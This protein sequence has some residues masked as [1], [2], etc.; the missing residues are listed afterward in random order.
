MKILVVRFKQI[1]DSILTGPLCYSLKKSFPDAQ[2]DY[3]VYDHIAPLFEK[4]KY[5]D[6]VISITKEERKQLCSLIK[7]LPLTI[8]GDH[9]FGEAVITRGGVDV[10]EINPSTMESKILKGLY[11]AG[12]IVDVDG[13]C[14]GYNLQWAWSSGYV[15]GRSCAA[16]HC[17]TEK[18]KGNR[19]ETDNQ[20]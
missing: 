6:N 19:K 18:Q 1:G 20:I 15:A 3:V 14:G 11:F 4:N 5:I 9:G 13:I 7:S 2:V 8:T 10:D 17:K 16:Q 12:E